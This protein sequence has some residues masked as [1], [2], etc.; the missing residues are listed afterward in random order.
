MFVRM[1]DDDLR[2][3]AKRFLGGQHRAD[4]LDRFYLDRF[5]CASREPM[6]FKGLRED[7]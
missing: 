4:D 1:I 2:L 5:P 6:A 7:L 3:R